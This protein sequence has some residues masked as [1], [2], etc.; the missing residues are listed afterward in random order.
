MSE[1][2]EATEP[3]GVAAAAAWD[4]LPSALESLGFTLDR[5][6]RG[7]MEL[8]GVTSPRFNRQDFR[9][10][11][12]RREDA[13]CELFFMVKEK[14]GADSESLVNAIMNFMVAMTTPNPTD[15]APRPPSS[16]APPSCLF[17]DAPVL[18]RAMR[19]CA[20]CGKALR[21]VR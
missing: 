21:T 11:L 7:N 18:D 14:R 6:D 8:S 1:I 16:L 12:R 15:T 9:I 19:F 13:C 5:A 17:C 2:I 10:G 4:I 3:L 20:Y